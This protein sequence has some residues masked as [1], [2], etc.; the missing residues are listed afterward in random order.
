MEPDVFRK[1]VVTEDAV[2]DKPPPAMLYELI[3]EPPAPVAPVIVSVTLL[4]V[5]TESP[6]EDGTV[7]STRV[8]VM[9]VIVGLIDAG[10]DSVTVVVLVPTSVLPL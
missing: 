9:P 4:F 6:Q 7:P 10:T 8:A 1:P 3:V 5:C 2:Y